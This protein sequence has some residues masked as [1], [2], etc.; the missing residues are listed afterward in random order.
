MVEEPIVL[1]PE[2][3]HDRYVIVR[4]ADGSPHPQFFRYS[5]ELW[6]GVDTFGYGT[7]WPYLVYWAMTQGLTLTSASPEESPC[8]PA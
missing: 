2:P 8:A 1:P 6:I 5:R 3:P 4:H 7:P